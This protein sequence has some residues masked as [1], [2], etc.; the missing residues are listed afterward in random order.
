MSILAGLRREAFTHHDP[1][2]VLTLL[3]F[4]SCAVF[5][6]DL[7]TPRGVADGH[8]Y[9]AVVALGLLLQQDR[10][11]VTLAAVCTA[12]AALGAWLSPPG[13]DPLL[14]GMNRAIAIGV[15]WVVTA[16]HLARLRT[17]RTRASEERGFRDFVENAPVALHWAGSDG[18]ILW[19]NAA[20]LALL[21]Y[22]AHEYVGHHIAEFHADPHTAERILAMLQ[23]NT[24]LHDHEARLRC[25]DGSIRN[26]L[27]SSN[28]YFRDSRF[29][30]TRCFTRDV[31]WH[32]QAQ[33]ESESRFRELADAA[34]VMIWMSDE[35][36]QCVYLN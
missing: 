10:E 16:F 6:V 5:L 17:Q 3:L 13:A 7:M 1:R 4:A 29:I 23:A 35:K 2:A 18:R 11:L 14:A 12:L 9:V 27:I 25:R 28:A 15:I 31:T 22:A 30:H 26:V 20:E 33:R 24:P 32:K 8:L 36:R 34:P 21:G 19:A